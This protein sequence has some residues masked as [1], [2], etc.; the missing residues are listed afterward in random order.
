[1]PFSRHSKSA[2][3]NLLQE[4]DVLAADFGDIYDVNN[5]PVDE[6]LR[7]AEKCFSDVYLP[8]PKMS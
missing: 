6:W 5:L 7:N 4:L 8:P 1:M 3:S 2:D